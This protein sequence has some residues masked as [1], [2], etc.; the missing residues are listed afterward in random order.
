M[1]RLRIPQN[2]TVSGCWTSSVGGVLCAPPLTPP[3]LWVRIRRFAKRYEQ[4]GIDL[5]ESVIPARANRGCS[6]LCVVVAICVY[7]GALY[8]GTGFERPH[9]KIDSITFPH[10]IL[11]AI[12]RAFIL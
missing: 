11:T 5:L 10:L 6:G 12:H 4:A 7:D 8:S 2:G 1:Y 3:Y 9:Q